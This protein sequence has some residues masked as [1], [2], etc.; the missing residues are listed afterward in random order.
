[1]VP[2][3][4]LEKTSHLSTNITLEQVEIEERV[5]RKA[6][7]LSLTNMLPINLTVRTP[8]GIKAK[9]WICDDVLVMICISFE[10]LTTL[11]E[12]LELIESP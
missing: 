8:E 6:T 10:F 5:I 9:S 12:T 7:R 4:W 3:K 11:L 2:I 1:M